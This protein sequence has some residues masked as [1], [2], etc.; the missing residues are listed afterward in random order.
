MAL[1]RVDQFDVEH[2]IINA[3]AV[4][5][6]Y[7]V[8]E[9]HAVKLD[10]ATQMGR[11]SDMWHGYILT[12]CSNEVVAVPALDVVSCAGRYSGGSQAVKRSW[13]HLCAPTGLRYKGVCSA[14]TVV[15]ERLL[16]HTLPCN[17]CLGPGNV[18]WFAILCCSI[19]PL[20]EVRAR[21]DHLSLA[22]EYE[23]T[24]CR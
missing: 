14:Q 15:F 20:Q 24:S 5:C 3:Q 6:Q 10:D 9:Q 22:P 23:C 1:R 7:I 12:E 8:V 11:L 4:Q 13:L 2:S 19:I 18:R 16:R 17:I 21:A